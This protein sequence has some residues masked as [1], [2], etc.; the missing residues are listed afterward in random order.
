MAPMNYEEHDY[1]VLEHLLPSLVNGERD[2]LSDHEEQ[3]LDEFIA[4]C[5]DNYYPVSSPEYPDDWMQYM[6]KC[7]ITGLIG[8]CVE[9]KK[10]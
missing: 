6:A 9:I 8:W 2:H 5:G 10:S 7:D 3:Q 4:E 1:V